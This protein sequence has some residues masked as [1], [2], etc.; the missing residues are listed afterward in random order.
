MSRRA[1][2]GSAFGF[3]EDTLPPE[4]GADP[5]LEGLAETP[6]APEAPETPEEPEP[7]EPAAPAEPQET[8]PEPEQP[9]EPPAPEAA[10]GAPE[11]EEE[12]E[13]EPAQPQR[14]YAGRY[15]SIEDFEAGYRHMQAKASRDAQ[16]RQDAEDRLTQ[17]QDAL[18]RA[19]PVIEQYLRDQQRQRLEG[20]DYEQDQQPQGLDPVAAQ[21]EAQ[22]A[23]QEE[24][25]RFRSEQERNEAIR[26]AERAVAEF[27]KEHPEVAPDSELDS[28]M[29]EVIESLNLEV[30]PETLGIAFE[31]AQDSDLRTVL[32]AQPELVDNDAGL[33]Y[34]RMQASLAKM[35]R[36]STPQ[37]QQQTQQAPQAPKTRSPQAEA[38]RAKAHV[39]TGGTGK[40]PEAPGGRPK[41]EFDEVL[42]LA[43]KEKK[44]AFF[45]G[46]S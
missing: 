38:A 42:E 15:R 28:Q 33:H 45:G 6:E 11:E 20:Y 35:A 40:P 3:P 43:Q 2:T 34:A 16:R 21:R 4:E 30:N 37:P 24:I 41:D 31:A 36:G 17:M 10:E 14:L 29:A 9:A 1:P 23:A 39:E 27:Q 46:L 7:A 22:R 8:P 18:Q 25:Q 19:A 44:S 26:Q 32:E 13:P 12:G 5:L